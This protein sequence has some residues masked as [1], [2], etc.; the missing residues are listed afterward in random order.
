MACAILEI[1]S[2]FDRLCETTAPN[3]LKFV[4]VSNFFSFTLIPIW[5]PLALDRIQWSSKS[6]FEDDFVL[7]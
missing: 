2:G 6:Y 1:N 5:M 4:T 7:K 3:Y